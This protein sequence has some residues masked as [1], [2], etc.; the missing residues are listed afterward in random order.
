[1]VLDLLL[2]ELVRLIRASGR[3]QVFATR[4]MEIY[5]VSRTTLDLMFE[6]L[7][8]SPS[9]LSSCPARRCLSPRS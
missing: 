9:P 5:R 6:A 3:T 2:R 4:E 8:Y 7:A 1:M